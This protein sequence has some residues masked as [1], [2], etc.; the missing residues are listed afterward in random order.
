MPPPRLFSLIHPQPW[1]MHYIPSYISLTSEVQGFLFGYIALDI[2][3]AIRFS[4][5]PNHVHCH[6]I[7]DHI[8][9][10]PTAHL[11]NHT[12]EPVPDS[13][14]PER[15]HLDIT[16]TMSGLAHFP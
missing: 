3:Y 14:Y 2:T 4:D 16:Y 9:T 12:C 15:H 11:L 10:L 13:G 7:L 8:N 6:H 5:L 1:P